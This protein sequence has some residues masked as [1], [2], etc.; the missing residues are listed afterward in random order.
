M[1][2]VLEAEVSENTVYTKKGTYHTSVLNPVAIEWING[3]KD[4]YKN[5]QCH[6]EDV[7]ARECSHKQWWFTIESQLHREDRSAIECTTGT[8]CWY[9]NGQ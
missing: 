7:S 2:T 1:G 6:R 4:W 9:Q 5:G 3:D 8:K